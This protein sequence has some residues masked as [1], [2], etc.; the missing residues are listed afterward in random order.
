MR[1]ILFIASIVFLAS[2][3]LLLASSY[4][5]QREYVDA[6][7]SNGLWFVVGLSIYL[8]VL[9]ILGIFASLFSSNRIFKLLAWM[10]VLN[11]VIGASVL[12]SSSSK[13][14]T[15][16]DELVGMFKGY[17]DKYDWKHRPNTSEEIRAATEAWDQLQTKSHCCGL[18]T[19][20]DWTQYR[21]DGVAEGLLPVSCCQNGTLPSDGPAKS[22]DDNS[23]I[24]QYCDPKA[25]K[26][27]SDGCQ[28]DMMQG[29]KYILYVMVALVCY[30]LL[31]AI[32]SVII[33]VCRPTTL[34]Y[35][36][37]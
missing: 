7:L 23:T 33:I 15:A 12:V 25:D 19:P 5:S 34:Y 24:G 27:W 26:F 17:Q 13:F 36:T 32:L 21:P 35:G 4:Q 9:A 2:S 11:A 37:Y 8:V 1:L 14:D 18:K 10:M 29:F 6:G 3:L 20:D 31:L 16:L 30:F 22:D 28:A